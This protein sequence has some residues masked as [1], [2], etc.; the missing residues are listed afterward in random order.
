MK[1]NN[2]EQETTPSLT[3]FVIGTKSSDLSTMNFRLQA[4]RDSF[5]IPSLSDDEGGYR[6]VF[7]DLSANN[8]TSSTTAI[9]NYGVNVFTISSLTNYACKLPQPTTGYNSIIIN[10]SALPI[11]IYPSN[12]GGRINNYP[13]DT[14]AVIPADGKPYT[15]I[16]IENPLPGEWTWLTP[17]I[18]QLVLGDFSISHT[19][20]TATN[21]YGVTQAGLGSSSGVGL[22]SGSITLTGEW[23]SESNPTTVSRIKCYSNIVDIDVPTVTNLQVAFITAYKTGASTVVQGQRDA[24]QFQSDPD[25]YTELKNG[26]GTLTAHPNEAIG[27]TY[28]LYGIHSSPVAILNSQIG[29]GGSF[30]N[31]YYTFGFFIPASALTKT[32]KFR[33]ILEYF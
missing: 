7:K 26:V 21:R 5:E 23:K 3:D 6:P 28:T 27:D 19:T 2:Y 18:N 16:C 24:F 11:Y 25:S 31:Y 30:S 29:T 12:I 13:I 22:S 17:A 15:F 9:L 10:N 8:T 14:P 4:I 32:Y 20:G 33:I 1:I